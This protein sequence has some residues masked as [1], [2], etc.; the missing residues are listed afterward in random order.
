MTI[1]ELLKE[2]RISQAKNQ[3]DFTHNGIII[4]QS[5]YSKVEKNTH[6]ITADSL[7]KLLH[8]NNIPLWTFFS[9]LNPNDDMQYQQI[10]NLHSIM[11]ST[12]YGQNQQ[13]L[14]DIKLLIDKTNLSKEDKNE[15]KLLVDGWIES[16]KKDPKSFDM[17]LRHKLKD[18]I[19][20]HPNLDKNTITLYCNFMVFYDLD[21]NKIIAKKIIQQYKDSDNVD[22]KIAILAIISNIL[23]IAIEKNQIEDIQ[24]FIDT[25]DEIPTLP[26]LFFYKNTIFFFKNLI[27]Y[28]QTKQNNSLINCK[29][30]IN[31]IINLDMKSYGDKI[32][33]FLN[34]HTK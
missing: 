19:F 17:E 15:E 1:G 8:F 28:K 6:R 14:N 27:I 25:A 2:Y 31:T 26:E 12:Y 7:I 9:R 34:K 16:L 13:K 32:H 18:K 21:S 24:L 33:K 3:K 23:A 10:S 11:I 22:I 29:N 20:S 30:A 5:Y 4:S